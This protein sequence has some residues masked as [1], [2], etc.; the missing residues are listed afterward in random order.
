MVEFSVCTTVF[1]NVNM[2][3]TCLSSVIRAFEGLDFEIVVVDNYSTDGPFKVL[4]EFARRYRNVRVFRFSCS[5][6]LGRQLAFEHSHGCYVV[7]I[8]GD[9]EYNFEKLRRILTVFRKQKSGK[10]AAVKF[11][12]SLCIYPTVPR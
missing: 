3:E 6:G 7:T 4:K 5:R 2:L 11:W 8:D 1:N 10:F 9:T 12:G